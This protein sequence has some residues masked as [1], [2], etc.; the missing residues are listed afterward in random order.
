MLLSLAVILIPI[1]LIVWAF[2][3]TPDEPEVDRVDWKPAVAEARSGAGYPV[4]APVEI[5]AD[6][7][8]VKARYAERGGRWVGQTQAA[9]N[10]L[11]LGFV[12]GD[13]VYIAVNQ[14]DEPDKAAYIASVTRSSATDGSAMVGDQTWQ[15]RVSEDG[16]TRSLVRAVGGSTAIVVGDAGYTALESFART[17][18]AS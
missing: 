15:R 6:W 2:T 16:R 1:L 12:S 3:R 9:G 13:D 14:S 5:P 10:R 4:L 11:E 17:L 8:P 18:K 7:K